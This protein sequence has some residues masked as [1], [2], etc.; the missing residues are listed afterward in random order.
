MLENLNLQKI[1][2][3]VATSSLIFAV[4][5]IY[6]KSLKASKNIALPRVTTKCPDY[7][8]LSSDRN[9]CVNT[10]GMNKGALS[11]NVCNAKRNYPCCT[12]GTCYIKT[13][14]TNKKEW[15]KKNKFVWDGI[16]N[17]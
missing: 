11:Y 10:N 15:A 2:L 7:W 12:E 1:V 9:A 8:D 17:G 13:I 5:I 14:R 16:Y 3:I 4:I 6:Y